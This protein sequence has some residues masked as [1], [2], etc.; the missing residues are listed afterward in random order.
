MF[1]FYAFTCCTCGV[2]GLDRPIARCYLVSYIT[3]LLTNY[4]Y[5]ERLIFS[6]Q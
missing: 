6:E 3:F 4:M 5:A 2:A 1:V